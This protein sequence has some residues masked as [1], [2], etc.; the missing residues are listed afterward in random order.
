M[1]N[2]VT[3]PVEALQRCIDAFPGDV[4]FFA[5]DLTTGA[6]FEHHGDDR[7][8]T[9]SVFKVPIMIAL[10]RMAQRGEINLDER[11]RLEPDISD[12]GTGLL[13]MLRDQPEL[14][15]RDYCRVMIAVSDNMAT[16]MLLRAIG[17][18]AVNVM[19]DELG[20]TN[21][22]VS[23][24]IGRWHFTMVGMHDAPMTRKNIRQAADKTLAGSFDYRGLVFSDSLS[25][26]V[27]SARDMAALLEKLHRGELADANTTA[28]MIDLLKSCAHRGMIPRY[29]RDGVEVAHKH[30]SSHR[31]KA[32]AGIIYLPPGPLIVAGF[33]LASHTTSVGNDTIADMTRLVTEAVAPDAIAPAT[34]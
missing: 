19:L 2:A 4:G 26:N 27:A 28:E 7:F 17:C 15:L 31:I 23:M 12:H 29:L 6:V 21:T 25:S 16:D 32:D 11:R 14:T 24:E 8:P 22:R 34:A 20:L 18:D 13:N 33:T 10:H 1:S 9:A 3:F 5:H 30:G